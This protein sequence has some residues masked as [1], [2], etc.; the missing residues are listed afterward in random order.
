MTARTYGSY[1]FRPHDALSLAGTEAGTWV[2][3]LEPAV[4]MRFRRVFGKVQ[5]TRSV[6][7]TVTNTIEVCHDLIWFMNRFPLVAENPTSESRLHAGAAAHI[8]L[9]RKIGAILEAQELRL[10]LPTMPAKDPRQYQLQTVE[11]LRAKFGVLCT[12]EVGLGKTFTGLLNA[13]HPDALPMLIVPPTHLPERWETE[14]KDAFP[15]LTYEIA[16]KSTPTAAIA[17]GNLPDVLIVPYSKL[18]GHAAYL[19]GL[20]QTVVFDEAQ[21]LRNGVNTDKGKAAALVTEKA[22]YVLGL[23]ATPIYN[24]GGEIWNIMDI[25]A[26]G[27]L[28]SREEFFREWGAA[29]TTTAGG[30]IADPAA[31]GSYLREQGMMIGHTR[32]EVGR[33]LPKTIKVP[34]LVE[35]D[36]AALADVDQD[37]KRL[38]NLILSASSSPQEK[39]Q[40][41]GEIDWKMRH[42]TGVDKAPYVADFVRMLLE[43]EERVIL[44]GW[45]RDVYD[46]WL[47]KL[48]AYQ[49][50]MYTGS[51]TPKK[52]N[53]ARTRFLHPLHNEDGEPYENAARVLI[54]SLRS[55]AGVDGLQ[56]VARVAVFG[57]LDWS[58]QVHEQGIGRLRRDGMTDDPPVAYFLHSD[59]GSDPKMLEVLNLKRQQAEPIVSPDGKLLGNATTE[60]GRARR[61]AEQVL[62]I[63]TEP[64]AE[65][66]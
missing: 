26:P 45:H 9:E 58:P 33:E 60:P 46:I 30:M 62:G 18:D 32:A 22:K 51:E 4:R 65:S 27:Q 21:D 35:S 11:L 53:E 61:L 38:A 37:L 31:L 28:G 48:K 15:W 23:T 12:D 55:G 13:T 42:A 19:A 66:A 36:Y 40:A 20:V 2:L 41:S 3:T 1:R 39:F 54:M 43:S 50:A 5:V 59:Q 34:M 63:T 56:K 17:A 47:D 6:E 7:V 49:P 44:F 14:L 57:E 29:T 64:E 8:E 52:K 24:Y 16:P 10:D 25:L